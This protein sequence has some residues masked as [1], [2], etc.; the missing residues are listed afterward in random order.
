M[1]LDV[2]KNL[3]SHGFSNLPCPVFKNETLRSLATWSKKILIESLNFKHDIAYKDNVLFLPPETTDSILLLNQHSQ[4]FCD[5]I[6]TFDSIAI[7]RIHGNDSG[8]FVDLL[9]LGE[10]KNTL[11]SQIKSSEIYHHLSKIYNVNATDIEYHIY[12]TRDCLQPRGWHLDG[13]SIKLFTYLT[14]VTIE[15]GPYAYQLNSHRYYSE[16]FTYTKNKLSGQLH[17]NKVCE[18]FLDE[19]SMHI[20]TGDFGSSFISD[21]SGIHRGLPQSRGKERHVLVAQFIV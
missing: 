3:Q 19:G 21:Q 14:D 20:C 11:N 12:S 9:G 7:K 8:V 2:I 18:D 16:S 13:P 4:Y 10:F 17:K 5:M 15:D 6:S 1:S